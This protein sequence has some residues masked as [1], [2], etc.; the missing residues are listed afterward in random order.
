MSDQLITETCTSQHTTLTTDKTSMPL[1]GFKPTISAG[2]WLQTYAL[3]RE[4]TGTGIYNFMCNVL[5]FDFTLS[6]SAC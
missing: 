5:F 4:A 2:Q 1:V 3:D 6:P